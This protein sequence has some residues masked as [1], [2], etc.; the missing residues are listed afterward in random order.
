MKKPSDRSLVPGEFGTTRRG[1]ISVTRADVYVDIADTTGLLVNATSGR[2]AEGQ[3]VAPYTLSVENLDATTLKLT[4]VDYPIDNALTLYI[5]EHEGAIRCLLVQPEP[6]GPTDSIALDRELNSFV[7]AADLGRPGRG[8]SPGRPGSV[9]GGAGLVSRRFHEVRQERRPAAVV[10]VAPRSR[11]PPRAP[12]SRD[13]RSRPASSR[14]PIDEL[15]LDLGRVRPIASQVPEVAEAVRRLPDRHLAPVV[16]G[17]ARASARRSGRRGAARGRPSC[18]PRPTRCDRR[19]TT[20]SIRAVQTSNAWSAGQSTSK[21]EPDRLDHR[22]RVRGR[23]RRQQARNAPPPRPRP[24]R[25]RP[26]RPRCPRRGAGRSG[27]SRRAPRRTR[28]A[29]FS[30]LRWRETAG[31]LIGSASASSWTDRPP[32]PSSSTIARRFGSPSASNGSPASV[33]GGAPIVGL[34]PTRALGARLEPA[35]ELRERRAEVRHRAPHHAEQR[36][37]CTPPAGRT[38]SRRRRSA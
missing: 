11:L 1:N 9:G 25:G 36:A 14:R 20:E 22:G 28:P 18:R 32:E 26:G 34:G 15:D 8:V 7:L 3:S 16:L 27:A 6:T 2:P 12:P 23:V 31:R 13:A 19:A 10:P 37:A 21:R 38:G 17:A 33:G 24:A 35:G 29:R 4:W 30:S 5:D